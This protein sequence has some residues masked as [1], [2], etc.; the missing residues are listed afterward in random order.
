MKYD[1]IKE[2]IFINRINRFTANIQID[3]KTHL[4]HVKNTGRLRELLITGTTCF[5]QQVDR[6][7]RKT[8]YSLIAVRKQNR[9]V[10]I[11]ST[12]PNKVFY[13]WVK[14]GGFCEGITL[15]NPEKTF[16]NS[17][18]DYYIEAEDRKI[19]VEVKGVTLQKD[20]TALFPDAP[21]ERGVKHLHE[22]CECVKKG[23]EAYV[24]FVVQMKGVNA[25]SPNR[26]M[27]REFADALF[28]CRE[29]GVNILCV[30][31]DVS[32]DTLNISKRIDVKL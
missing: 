32:P 8:K 10:N 12:A 2:G 3:K 29:N 14:M 21:T 17:R 6:D 11:D 19:F 4:C 7:Q 16:G 25:F 18:F 28:E 13:E 5:V 1:N 27:H 22:L 30:D 15:I 23:Y 20:G 31:C 24:V 26:E 9:V